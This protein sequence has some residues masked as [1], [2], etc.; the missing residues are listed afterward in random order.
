MIDMGSATV[1]E[2]ESITVRVSR[3]VPTVAVSEI[4]ITGL[5]AVVVS[6]VIPAIVGVN[7]YLYVEVPAPT[8][9]VSPRETFIAFLILVIPVSVRVP[10]IIA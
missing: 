3:Y 2:T 9:N 8:V 1:A 10:L 7:V 4:L 6:K 5:M